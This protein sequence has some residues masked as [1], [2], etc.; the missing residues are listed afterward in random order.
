MFRVLKRWGTKMKNNYGACIVVL[1]I[2]TSCLS[3]E[4]QKL[5]EGQIKKEFYNSKRLA[6]HDFA[7]L[8][9]KMEKDGLL[10][11]VETYN[12]INLPIAY[13][14]SLYPSEQMYYEVIRQPEKKR[15]VYNEYGL[16]SLVGADK[17][18]NF[19]KK[20]LVIIFI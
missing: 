16:S 17:R 12:N 10:H 1:I 3:M 18:K 8:S 11:V 6:I 4:F 19:E 20:F 5:N 2:T 14:K 7:V 9:E 13:S 15:I